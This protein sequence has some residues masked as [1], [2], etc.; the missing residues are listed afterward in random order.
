MKVVFEGTEE[1]FNNLERIMSDRGNLPKKTEPLIMWSEQDVLDNYECTTNEAVSVI[2]ES[3]NG[4]FISG[5]IRDCINS[6]A[7]A[8]GLVKKK[9]ADHG[10]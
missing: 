5:E 1:Q 9:E 3:L 4:E 6:V 7:E 10:A 8:M 2:E